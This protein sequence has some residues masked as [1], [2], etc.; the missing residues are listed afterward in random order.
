MCAPRFTLH[1]PLSWKN[2]CVTPISNFLAL[3]FLVASAEEASAGHRRT[4]EEGPEV[5]SLGGSPQAGCIL[6]EKAMA[7]SGAPTPLSADDD[8]PPP[9]HPPLQG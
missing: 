1:S 5:I 7:P 6:P 3:W 2:A 9:R 4:R 8:P